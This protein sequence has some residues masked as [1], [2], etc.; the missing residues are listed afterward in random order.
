[1][2]VNF[3]LFVS[4]ERNK[5]KHETKNDNKQNVLQFLKDRML[6][7]KVHKISHNIDKHGFYEELDGK[8]NC[9]AALLSVENTGS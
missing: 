5:I 9:A 3:F 1:M 8:G 2:E 7:V 4:S 6:L